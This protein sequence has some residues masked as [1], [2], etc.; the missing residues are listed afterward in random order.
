M[1][2]AHLP[3]GD[4]CRSSLGLPLV[5]MALVGLVTLA[6]VH[7]AEPEGVVSG[8]VDAVVEAVD[9]AAE[10]IDASVITIDLAGRFGDMQIERN[11]AGELLITVY[12]PSG[13][14]RLTPDEFARIV[15]RAKQQ[16][17]DRGFLFVLFN[18]TSWWGVLWVSVGFLGQAV[19]TFRMV[20][21]W[22]ASEKQRKSVIPVAFWWG[23]LIGGVML[24]AYFVWRK[25]IVGVVGQST[26]TFIYARNLWLIYFHRAPR[27][28][29]SAPPTQ[30]D[31]ANAHS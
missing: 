23:S 14:V 15:H 30:P 29:A 25:D 3:G 1:P 22:V 7:A 4:T 18:I 12:T 13:P 19:F 16:Q 20:L 21:Q 5:V 2:N 26:G 11:D 17:R 24:L 8:S 31:T 9:Q 6:W 28:V 10:P 27:G